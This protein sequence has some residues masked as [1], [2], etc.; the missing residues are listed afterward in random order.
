MKPPPLPGPGLA[1]TYPE[2]GATRDRDL[3]GDLPPGYHHV[4]YRKVIGQ[5]EA[6][7][8]GA[9]ETLMT[10]GM[11][12]R[13]GFAVES[14]APRAAEGVVVRVGAGAGPVRLRIPC[15]V[16]YVV[17]EARRKGFGYGTLPGHPESGEEA[18]V[19]SL[20]DDGAVLATIV[21][22]SRPAL[23]WVRAGAPLGRQV[24]RLATARYAAAL[25]QPG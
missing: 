13:A 14:S 25:R 22:F 3:G 11:H 20:R 2:V 12:R 18:F 9:V 7:F 5:G 8:A 6:A 16:V 21:A 4:R 19:V 15:R 1:L 17:E 23:W 24:Q 10:F